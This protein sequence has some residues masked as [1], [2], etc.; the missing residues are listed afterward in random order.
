ML[1]S[2]WLSSSGGVSMGDRSAGVADIG[3]T[4]QHGRIPTTLSGWL[5]GVLSDWVDSTKVSVGTFCLFHFLAWKKNINKNKLWTCAIYKF[6]GFCDISHLLYRLLPWLS[7]RI[8]DHLVPLVP[9]K[10]VII[11]FSEW[12]LL[13]TKKNRSLS[14]FGGRLVTTAYCWH[15]H[16][17]VLLLYAPVNVFFSIV[18][19]L[20]WISIKQRLTCLAQWYKT[21]HPVSLEQAPIRFQVRVQRSGIDTIKYHTWPRIPIG[22]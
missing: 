19:T 13:I 17:F 5:P 6:T 8:N 10:P 3:A 21:V 11:V 22:K 15:N 12:W 2:P 4:T 1:T 16:L 7:S 9:C 20:G 14:I 18:W